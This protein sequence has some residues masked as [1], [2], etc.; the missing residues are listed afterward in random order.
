MAFPRARPL[1]LA[2]FPGMNL[3]AASYPEFCQTSS[4]ISLSKGLSIPCF[5]PSKMLPRSGVSTTPKYQSLFLTISV[6][7]WPLNSSTKDLTDFLNGSK[8]E[9]NISGYPLPLISATS[10]PI[11]LSSDRLA[12]VFNFK[13]CLFSNRYASTVLSSMMMVSVLPSSSISPKAIPFIRFLNILLFQYLTDWPC[14]A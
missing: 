6:K 10:T 4:K 3:S 13:N 14:D 12:M 8:A 11:N 2:R 5:W 1:T 7:V 9:I